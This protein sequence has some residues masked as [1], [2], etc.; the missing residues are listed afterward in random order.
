ML[1]A[2]PPAH[3]IDAS[4]YNPLG[5][6]EFG[7]IL[8]VN[9]WILHEAGG[10]WYDCFHYDI[11]TLDMRTRSVALTLIM[12]A[13]T[14]ESFGALLPLIKDPRLC[15]LLDFWLPALRALKLSPRVLL[16]L[17][18][19]N[20]V[21]ASLADRDGLPP[22]V[23]AALWLRYML[24]AEFATRN[25]PRHILSYG[26]LLGDWRESMALAGERAA[27]VWPAT[28][29]V[30]VS[31]VARYLD[32]RSR[33][34]EGTQAPGGMSLTP[35]TFWLEEVYAALGGLERDGSTASYL[36]RL[37]LVRQAFASWCRTEG[38]VLAAELLYEH[39]IRTVARVE[40]PEEWLRTAERFVSSQAAPAG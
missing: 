12:L 20:E 9:D 1:G 32:P 11:D 40:T 14:S 8:C 36:E 31:H 38:R 2:T 35:L 15:L 30:P 6:W 24:A 13:M 5:Y 19:P 29:D 17:R 3:L 16:V 10:A 27:I 7:A 4:S 23:S 28:L 34:H 18:H 25:C 37:D 21:V 39:P 22:V 33:H 26:R